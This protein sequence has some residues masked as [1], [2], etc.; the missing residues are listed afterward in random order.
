MVAHG[1][2]MASVEKDAFL[3]KTGAVTLKGHTSQLVCLSQVRLFAQRLFQALSAGR[4]RRNHP[5]KKAGVGPSATIY[6]TN[7]ALHIQ[8]D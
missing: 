4:T 7:A 1:I 3:L 8:V 2:D 6:Q 5:E